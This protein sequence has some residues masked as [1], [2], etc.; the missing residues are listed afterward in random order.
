[1]K[2]KLCPKCVGATKVMIPKTNG[3]KGF[4]YV[5]CSLCNGTGIVSKETEED[6]LL[7][8]NEDLIDNYD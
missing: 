7:S 4:E 3:S 8:L 6:Y 1:M 2:N 5:D